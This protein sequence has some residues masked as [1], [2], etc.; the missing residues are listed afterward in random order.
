M[1]IVGAIGAL[2]VFS[3]LL[4]VCAGLIRLSEIRSV[5]F[6]QE[7][8]GR[9]GRTF[10]MLKLATMKEDAHLRGPLVSTSSDARV[11]PIG[12]VI[13]ALGFNE[14][15]QFINVLRGEMSIVGPR[16]ETPDYMKY[17]PEEAAPKILSVRPGI[18]SLTTLRYWN[19]AS[20]LD[21]Q[22]DP[23]RYYLEKVMPKKLK[24]DLWY[25]SNRTL[26]MDLKIMLQTLGKA[27][28]GSRLF[29]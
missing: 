11:T 25:V 27:F 7:R 5:I 6:R 21:G 14:L 22:E 3:P 15:P 28:G 4:L 23:E 19:E 9:Y 1:D 20:L 8:V 10:S 18:T 12:R 24:L 26:G 16:P 17:W 2:V 29:R 13:R